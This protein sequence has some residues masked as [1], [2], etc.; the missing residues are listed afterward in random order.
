MPLLFQSLI[1][2][3]WMKHEASR[4]HRRTLEE[5]RSVPARRPSQ[6]LTCAPRPHKI[7]ITQS[8]TISKMFQIS[9]QDN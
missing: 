2:P 6:V 5:G 9:T 8:S 4:E 3:F 1:K 7:D